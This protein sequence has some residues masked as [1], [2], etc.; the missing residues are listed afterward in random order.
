MTT[1]ELL[2]CPFCGYQYV[3]ILY[4][5]LRNDGLASAYVCCPKCDAS[6][7]AYMDR[8]AAIA[9]WNTRVNNPGKPE[10]SD[11]KP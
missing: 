8:A 1:P 7:G 6:S 2:P 5:P 11:G 9:G 3:G 4:D 10:S